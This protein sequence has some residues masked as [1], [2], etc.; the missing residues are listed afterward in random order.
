MLQILETT[1]DSVTNTSLGGVISFFGWI[2]SILSTIIDKIVEL[3]NFIKEIITFI[4]DVLNI[5]PNNI[6]M[7]LT[8]ALTIV[9]FAAI[10]KFVK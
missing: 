1:T 7:F 2:W 9:V 6:L 8:A 4:P 3:I 10:Y 5:L